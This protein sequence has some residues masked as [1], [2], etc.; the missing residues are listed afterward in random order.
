VA[1][2]HDAGAEP[3]IEGSAATA[4][5]ARGRFIPDGVDDPHLALLRVHVDRAQ[6]WQDKKPK[7]L[8][9]AEVL[10]GLVRGVPPKSGEEGRIDF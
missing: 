9:L 5:H 2:Q 10:V 7:V 3:A 4:Q 6:Y 1:R 8:Q